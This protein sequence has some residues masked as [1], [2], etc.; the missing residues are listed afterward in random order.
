MNPAVVD[1]ADPTTTSCPECGT[2]MAADQ[3]YCLDC[4][5]RRGDPRLAIDAVTSSA[6]PDARGG[7]GRI[8]PPPSPQQGGSRGSRSPNAALIAGV[9]TL[10]LAVGVGFLV[11]RTVHQGASSRSNGRQTI[12]IENGGEAPA[13]EPP[14]GSH[15]VETTPK[16]GGEGQGPDLTPGDSPEAKQPPAGGKSAQEQEELHEKET[17]EQLHPKVPLAKPTAKVGETCEAG[18][19]GCGKDHKFHGVFFGAEE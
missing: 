17:Q 12:T 7:A 19:A 4:G 6:S 11:G 3:R 10:I 5:N 14:S 16:H 9:A 13:V 2:P 1:L 18:T 15:P 8:P